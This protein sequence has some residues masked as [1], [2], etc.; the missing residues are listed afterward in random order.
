MQCKLLTWTIN[1]GD[2]EDD[3]ESDEVRKSKT[4]TLGSELDWSFVGKKRKNIRMRRIWETIFGSD[5]KMKTIISSRYSRI[6]TITTWKMRRNNTGN[7]TKLNFVI[8]ELS[9]C[10]S[11]TKINS[12]RTIWQNRK[13]NGCQLSWESF[14]ISSGYIRYNKISYRFYWSRNH[15]DLIGV[16]TILETCGIKE[17]PECVISR[18]WPLSIN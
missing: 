4:T 9:T 3:M 14:S 8:T 13:I 5:P 16:E 18:C 6:E 10:T 1:F 15:G 2:V 11:R 7:R 12:E 17:L